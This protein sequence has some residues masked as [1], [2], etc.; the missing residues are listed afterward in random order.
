MNHEI[1]KMKKIKNIKNISIFA[2]VAHLAEQCFR[3]AQAGG[4][5]PPIGYSI[6]LSLLLISSTV[7]ME[8]GIID[9][10]PSGNSNG[11]ISISENAAVL[12][13]L[14]NY[15][16]IDSLKSLSDNFV[17]NIFYDT[18]RMRG[19]F[20]FSAEKIIKDTIIN[21][22]YEIFSKNKCDTLLFEIPVILETDSFK[23]IQN[24]SLFT[25]K[26]FVNSPL[27][28]FF[29]RYIKITHFPSNYD[30]LLLL[31]SF[32][33]NSLYSF[34]PRRFTGLYFIQLYIEINNRLIEIE[35]NI[36]LFFEQSNTLYK[37]II[38]LDI[39]PNLSS[40]EFL[41]IITHFFDTNS[42]L[43]LPLNELE[44]YSSEYTNNLTDANIF[45]LFQSEYLMEYE[46]TFYN[47]ISNLPSSINIFIFGNKTIKSFANSSL[48]SSFLE[49]NSFIF[50][51]KISS[52]SGQLSGKI[53]ITDELINFSNIFPITAFDTIVNCENFPIIVRNNNII[54]SSLEISCF[55][56]VDI[57]VN[58]LS[59]P[60]SPTLEDSIITP[61]K[62][63]KAFPN[64]VGMN[65]TTI[66]FNIFSQGEINISI[67]DISGREI[68]PVFSGN[69]YN[70]T[71]QFFWNG[72]D[73]DNNIL[74]KGIYFISTIFRNNDE[75]YKL[76]HKLLLI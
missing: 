62:I 47:Y 31:D 74:P 44:N 48:L 66:F 19:H 33:Q 20:L 41:K 26:F 14:E 57:L 29:K 22:N 7:Y 27:N 38:I 36:N 37:N 3:K 64:P 55:K 1:L 58:Y 6:V 16:H 8:Y 40:L 45:I 76:S 52:L 49:K 56:D 65:G 34:I 28:L 9:D 35:N 21:I 59:N 32:D 25:F 71:F 17:N 4:S 13:S 5:I 24:N 60:S 2:D 72:K 63:E 67:T 69:I 73:I 11:I 54:I 18:L 61:I 30:T 75:I 43:I 12:F 46:N 23:T 51:E 39:E 15:N 70:G 53:K 68:C 42:T 10:P 50:N